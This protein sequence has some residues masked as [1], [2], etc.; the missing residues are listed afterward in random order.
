MSGLSSLSSNGMAL[1]TGADEFGELD[2]SSHLVGQAGKLREQM[3]AEGYLFLR[4]FLSRETVLAAREE[5]LFKF[6]IVG[7]ID[8]INYPLMDGILSDES[9][10]HQV[11]VLAFT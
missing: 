10:I 9:Y 7:E 8:S 3:D 4:G 1:G 5:I 2:D 11:N 6:A